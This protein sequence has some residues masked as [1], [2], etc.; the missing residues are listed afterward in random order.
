MLND[1]VRLCKIYKAL[2]M[3]ELRNINKHSYI[4]NY[5]TVLEND[6]VIRGMGLTFVFFDTHIEEIQFD[7]RRK[8]VSKAKKQFTSYCIK[9][10]RFYS[11]LHPEITFMA[12]DDWIRLFCVA[13]MKE[14][15]LSI[16]MRVE[17]E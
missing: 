17:N 4:G 15:Q 12:W 3:S 10:L 7:K 2:T 5:I 16:I 14:L 11:C 1:I 13:M 6:L 8:N 9:N